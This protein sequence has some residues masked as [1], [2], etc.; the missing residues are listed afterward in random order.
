MWTSPGQGRPRVPYISFSRKPHI[1][2]QHI[3]ITKTSKNCERSEILSYMQA[4]KLAGHGVVAADRKDKTP[5]TESKDLNT[6]S[7]SGS[8]SMNI[9]TSSP[10]FSSHRVMQKAR[11][12]LHVH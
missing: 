11:C 7:V 9:L 12:Y 3:L 6:H 2:A 4:D 10:S 1:C 8:Q 5:G